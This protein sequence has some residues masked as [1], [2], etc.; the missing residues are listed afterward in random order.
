MN[1]FAELSGA[2]AIYDGASFQGG[3]EALEALVRH[4]RRRPGACRLAFELFPLKTYRRPDFDL[5][6]PADPDFAAHSRRL[7]AAW[8]QQQTSQAAGVVVQ[9]PQAVLSSFNVYVP[10][11]EGY[12]VLY[13]TWR[14]QDRAG[15]GL[16][17]KAQL[18]RARPITAW[19][20]PRS[21]LFLSGRG[22]FTYGHWL[23]DDVPRAA[24]VRALHERTGRP[25]TVLTQSHTLVLDTMREASIA[26]MIPPEIPYEIVFLDPELCYRIDE[27]YVPLPVTSHPIWKS[28]P[29]LRSMAA[30]IRKHLPL[31]A[32][33]P[34]IFVPRRR[35]SG[36]TLENGQHV[37]ARLADAGF[38]AVDTEAMDFA[39]QVA[40]F[41]GAQTVIGCMGA[42][43]VNSVFSPPGARMIYLAP[44]GWEEPFYWDLA[45]PLGH[46]YHVCFARC[47]QPDR[48][49]NQSNYEITPE[50]LD[51][52]LAVADRPAMR[53]SRR[54]ST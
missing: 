5:I 1:D 32:G 4:A 50:Q 7:A 41:A 29:A 46:A 24:A 49:A 40:A 18:D 14:P 13:E 35:R 38:V 44:S 20:G 25:V 53:P 23:I 22:W 6:A 34:R 45:G 2:P 36:R 31:P 47:T 27:L 8:S 42:A 33:P 11:D 26:A 19:Q 10:H 37:A 52:V 54:T 28:P 51:A 39:A 30:T 9:L 43:M 48:P 21:V 17:S 15:G 12:D 16:R 3:A